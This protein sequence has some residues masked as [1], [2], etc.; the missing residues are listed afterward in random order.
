MYHIFFIHSSIDGHLDC[1]H[2]LAIVNNTAMNIGGYMYLFEL[3]F[4][5]SS[6]IYPRLKLLDYMVVFCFSFRPHCAKCGI[7]VPQPGIKPVPPA[8]G[9]QNLNHWTAREVPI[10]RGVFCFVLFFKFI[11]GCLG[12]SLLHTGFL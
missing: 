2:I 1:F 10:F 11:L 6:D 8:L 12:S 9:V 5:F 7:L 3:V 4:A